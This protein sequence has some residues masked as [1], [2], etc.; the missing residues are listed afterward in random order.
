MR[1]R[2]NDKV[3]S[4]SMVATLENQEGG[5]PSEELAEEAEEIAEEASTK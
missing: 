4:I 2:P 1:M 5:V 3:A